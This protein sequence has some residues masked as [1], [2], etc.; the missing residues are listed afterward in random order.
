MT[1][2]EHVKAAASGMTPSRTLLYAASSSATSILDGGSRGGPHTSIS[3]LSSQGVALE[4][5]ERALYSRQRPASQRIH[6]MFSPMKEEKVALLLDWI[7]AMN[8]G[9]ATFGVS[10]EE[11]FNT[12]FIAHVVP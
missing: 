12:L 3:V 4:E 11:T 9:L 7:Q 2:A 6:W 1:A 10:K 5:A 8:H